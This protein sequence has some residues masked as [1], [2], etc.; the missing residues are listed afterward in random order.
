MTKTKPS[1]TQD[2]DPATK[3]L[4]AQRKRAARTLLKRRRRKSHQ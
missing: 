1:T 3:V 4:I 2:L